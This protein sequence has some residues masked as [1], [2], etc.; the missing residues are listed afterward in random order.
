[1]KQ[2]TIFSEQCN[3]CKTE[4]ILNGKE[5][6]SYVVNAELKHFCKIHT[7]GKEPEKDCMTEYVKDC[8]NKISIIPK[9]NTIYKSPFWS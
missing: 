7:P 9:P 5:A 4:L 1:M 6:D 2:K 8:K 3:W